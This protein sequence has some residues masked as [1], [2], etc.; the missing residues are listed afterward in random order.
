MRSKVSSDLCSID[1][2]RF[3]VRGL[4]EIPII[5]PSAAPESKSGSGGGSA[6]KNQP[7]KP[8]VLTFLPWIHVE[9]SDFF[10]IMEKWKDNDS[11]TVNGVLNNNLPV[12]G[13][14]IGTPVTL[15]TRQNGLRPIAVLSHPDKA[16]TA[17]AKD[18][19]DGI[20]ISRL[21]TIFET[22]LHAD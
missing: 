21:E 4:L 17:L 15:T 2:V 6:G 13:D 11:F 5:S 18:I 16:P 14:T 20:N 10:K 1:N 19:S 9:T 7:T 8:P 22:L 3:F 12:Y